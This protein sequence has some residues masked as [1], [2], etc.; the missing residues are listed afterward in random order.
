MYCP[1][2]DFIEFF[3]LLLRFAVLLVALPLTVYVLAMV[4]HFENVSPTF[5]QKPNS[6]TNVEFT[7][8]CPAIANTMLVAVSL[9][10]TIT[11]VE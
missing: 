8:V 6:S 3:C 2:N 5:A 4:G 1:K 10:H 7:N 9:C 11:V